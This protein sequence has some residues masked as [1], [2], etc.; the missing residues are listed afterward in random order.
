LGG[1]PHHLAC[2]GVLPCSGVKAVGE[3]HIH[4]NPVPSRT[5]IEIRVVHSISKNSQLEVDVSVI[6]GISHDQYP[7]NKSF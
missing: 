3:L 6:V 7:L 5:R 1:L 4:L 2:G